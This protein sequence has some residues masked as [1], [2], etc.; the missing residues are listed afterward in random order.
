MKEKSYS[1]ADDQQLMRLSNIHGKRWYLIAKIM[2]R[3][4]DSVQ[5]RY[6]FL[7][8]RGFEMPPED[9]QALLATLTQSSGSANLTN[10]ST[11]SMEASDSFNEYEESSHCNAPP[12]EPNM[13]EDSKIIFKK[14]SALDSAS[15]KTRRPKTEVSRSV[16]PETVRPS[17]TDSQFSNIAE[18]S[19]QM[20]KP[21][22]TNHVHI[23]ASRANNR[24]GR[25][26][27]RIK[28]DN[29]VQVDKDMHW[30]ETTSKGSYR[31]ALPNTFAMHGY[32]IP[33]YVTQPLRP[34]LDL[35]ADPR[36]EMRFYLFSDSRM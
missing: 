31:N 24:N 20:L 34:L 1:K 9:E 30:T 21:S 18:Q 5:S 8:I 4:V 13:I 35:V 14:M 36:D 17:F 10:Y 3:S 28:P 7:R 23:L 25:A 2:C 27:E 12:T 26:D 16:L 15:S 22:Q 33:E 19:L 11:N 29:G 6:R 32:S